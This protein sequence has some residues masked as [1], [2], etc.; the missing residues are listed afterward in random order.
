M[1]KILGSWSGMRKYLEEEMLAPSLKKRIRYSCSTFVGMDGCCLFGIYV[2]GKLIKQFS[3]ETVAK[4]AY[5]GN[6]PTHIPAFWNAYWH[7]KETIPLEK[8]E[9]F[10]D[11]EFTQALA[12]YRNAD[13][14]ESIFSSNPLVRMFAILDRRIGKQTLEKI[15]LDLENQSQWLQFFYKLRFDA[16]QIRLF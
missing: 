7:E 10:D 16:D 4:H 1:G 13:I 9:S 15:K 2:D 3:M 6:N 12:L 11:T 5:Q 14:H 8:R